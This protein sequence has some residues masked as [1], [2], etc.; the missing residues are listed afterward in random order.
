MR[1]SFSAPTN[2]CFCE[3][4]EEFLIFF[5]N[6]ILFFSQYKYYMAA[7]ISFLFLNLYKLSN[8]TWSFKELMLLSPIANVKAVWSD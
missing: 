6:L 7:E 8:N 1:I 3:E 2:K 5:F 4:Q